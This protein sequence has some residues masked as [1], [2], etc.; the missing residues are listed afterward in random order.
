MKDSELNNP[1]SQKL[2]DFERI[3]DISPSAEWNE[4]LMN[5]ISLVNPG[6]TTKRTMKKYTI[7]IIFIILVN[8]GF[9]V[10]S[11]VKGANRSNSRPGDLNV[12]S[13]ELMIN[14]VSINS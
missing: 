11:F 8:I 10:N 12:I 14:P 7:V 5:R 3:G 2:A 13:N 9:I 1:V 6:T 4:S